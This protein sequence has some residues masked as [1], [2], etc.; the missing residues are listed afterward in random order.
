M[1]KVDLA[2]KWHS[3]LLYQV[4]HNLSDTISP[5]NLKVMK[6]EQYHSKNPRT[7]KM[8]IFGIL[9]GVLTGPISSILLLFQPSSCPA[10]VLLL[11]CF[12]SFP[13]SCSAP[14]LLLW[15]AHASAPTLLLPRFCPALFLLM[16]SSF[17]TQ[18]LPCLSLIL[19]LPTSVW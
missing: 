9:T 13:Y 4:K 11:P 15:S 6:V 17:S 10:P 12:R 14:L 1:P 18:L 3:R 8:K 2:K 19:P 5:P 16:L 7:L